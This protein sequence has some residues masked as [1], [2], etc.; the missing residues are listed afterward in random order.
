[1]DLSVLISQ[2]GAQ[3]AGV[4]LRV[5]IIILKIQSRSKSFH[6]HSRNSLFKKAIPWIKKFFKTPLAEL[7]VRIF[8]WISNWISARTPDKLSMSVS[9]YS[10]NHGYIR[11]SSRVDIRN[12]DIHKRISVRGATDIEAWFTMDIRGC[13]DNSSRISVILRIS[14]RTAVLNLVSLEYLPE[15]PDMRPIVILPPEK[16]YSSQAGVNTQS[17]TEPKNIFPF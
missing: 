16:F 12:T 3:S 6:S 5:F 8:A 10:Y 1:M 2:D 17:I 11:W 13:T 14:K 7:S 15:K 4:F 9:N